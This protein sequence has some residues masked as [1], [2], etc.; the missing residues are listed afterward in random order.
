MEEKIILGEKINIRK[1]LIIFRAILIT[2]TIGFVLYSVIGYSTYSKNQKLAVDTFI[3]IKEASNSYN[4]VEEILDDIASKGIDYSKYGESFEKIC[5]SFKSD[6][7]SLNGMSSG[8]YVNGYY[9]DQT[10]VIRAREKLRDG[11]S[12]LFEDMFGHHMD[13]QYPFAYTS[14]FE[15][16]GAKISNDDLVPYAEMPELS[17]IWVIIICLYF[18]LLLIT[19]IIN[20]KNNKQELRID[21]NVVY[22]KKSK[23]KTLEIPVSR[24]SNIKRGFY[25]SVK[26]NSPGVKIRVSMLKNQV[27]IINLL[28]DMQK[29]LSNKKEVAEPK[30]N[31]SYAQLSELKNL[32]DNNIITQEEFD[33]KKK[34]LLG[35]Q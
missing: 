16:L 14:F 9:I 7:E 4:S 8:F 3:I 26:V 30:A 19:E 11:M 34:Q 25:K 6:L 20:L 35:L 33:A 12:D 17:G 13:A 32:L 1:K 27:D 24:I 21:N 5:K 31:E 18:V 29:N 28:T 22:C 10:D 2:I 23:K 15:Y